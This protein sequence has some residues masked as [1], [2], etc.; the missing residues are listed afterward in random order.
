[1]K[2]GGKRRTQLLE[3]LKEKITYWNFKRRS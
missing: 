1:M 3:D 2:K